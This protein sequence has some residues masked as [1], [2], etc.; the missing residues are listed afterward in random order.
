M[1]AWFNG[2]KS[3]R[4]LVSPAAAGELPAADWVDG[5]AGEASVCVAGGGG[6]GISEPCLFRLQPNASIAVAQT[7]SKHKTYPRPGGSIAT[8]PAW[9]DNFISET[10]AIHFPSKSRL[11]GLRKSNSHLKQTQCH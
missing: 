10:K 8:R 1:S 3:G 9:E 2:R 7:S 4:A 11:L 5:A 6:A